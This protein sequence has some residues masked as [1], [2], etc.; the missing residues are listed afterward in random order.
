MLVWAGRRLAC[1]SMGSI[2]CR[3]LSPFI[4]AASPE[5]AKSAE[6]PGR[7]PPC[8]GGRPRTHPPTPPSR[9]RPPTSPLL[10]PLPPSPAALQAVCLLCV[11]PGGVRGAARG[12]HEAHAERGAPGM[13]GVSLPLLFAPR[14][15]L[16][17]LSIL[18]AE[19]LLPQAGASPGGGL[20]FSGGSGALALNR[21][22]ASDMESNRESWGSRPSAQDFGGEE[23]EALEANTSLGI[24]REPTMKSKMESPGS[25]SR[26]TLTARRLRRWRRSTRRRPSCWTRWAPASP[27]PCGCTRCAVHALHALHEQMG[28]AAVVY[29]CLR[30]FPMRWVC[31]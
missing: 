6:L 4:P 12:A 29:H 11:H 26:R 30:V 31:S 16:L 19:L 10:A 13:L 1:V 8:A 2:P 17:M 15:F 21:D 23:A 9:L 27:P 24:C 7:A 5:A 25:R 20:H 22:R 14:S 28:R 18:S 3:R